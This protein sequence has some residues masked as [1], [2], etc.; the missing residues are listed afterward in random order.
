MPTS[1]DCA[2]IKKR[3]KS[4][5][6]RGKTAS[7]RAQALAGFVQRGKLSNPKSKFTFVDDIEKI[8]LGG[9]I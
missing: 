3:Y 2:E 8:G 5:V 9:S 7:P 6:F 4:A 1:N